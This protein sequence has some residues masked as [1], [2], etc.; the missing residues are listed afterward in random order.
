M[1][2]PYDAVIPL[3][4]AN[5]PGEVC[6]VGSGVLVLIEEEYFL[7]SAAHV[8]DHLDGHHFLFIPGEDRIIQVDGGFAQ[9][10]RAGERDEKASLLDVAYY[11]LERSFV[12]RLSK[13]YHPIAK[14]EIGMLDQALDGDLYS[15]AGYPAATST[16]EPDSCAAEFFAMTGAVPH[17]RFYRKLGYRR[18]MHVLTQ[19]N[20]RRNVMLRGPAKST[21][22]PCGISGGAVFSWPRNANPLE[23]NPDPKLVGIT[24]EWHPRHAIFA[25][26]RI[27]CFM[28][29]IEMNNPI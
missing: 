1:A 12:K 25:A 23:P 27:W 11:H 24:T 20:V 18:D 6:L 5:N 17:D 4:L 26:T 13:S 15:L 28:K 7:L 22:E 10:G 3:F 14:A 21:P 29:C 19:F 16:V 2:H 8:T 9:L